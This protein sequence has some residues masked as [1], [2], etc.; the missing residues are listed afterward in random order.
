[1]PNLKNNIPF[2]RRSF[3]RRQCIRLGQLPHYIHF[4]SI[5]KMST[6]MDK[7]DHNL[8]DY[9]PKDVTKD[10]I[11]GAEDAELRFN[12]LNLEE[13]EVPSMDEGAAA[14]PDIPC[15]EG[16]CALP[17][18]PKPTQEKEDL[19]PKLSELVSQLVESQVGHALES[20]EAR[21]RAA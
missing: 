15:T 18:T 12:N 2:I 16:A 8:L 14:N 3:S 11:S 4:R 19:D 7:E 20:S 1:M 10:T 9:E 13:G 21:P 17:A 5:F 6:T